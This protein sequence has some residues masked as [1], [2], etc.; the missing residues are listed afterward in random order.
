MTRPVTGANETP[1]GLPQ[2]SVAAATTKQPPSQQQRRE[3]SARLSEGTAI[4]ST[5]RPETFGKAMK[6]LFFPITR[7]IRP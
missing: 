2:P 7:S 6:T 4:E 3:A 1:A 5:E